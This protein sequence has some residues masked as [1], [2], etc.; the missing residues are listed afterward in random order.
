MVLD[1]AGAV[2]VVE[3][4]LDLV[5]VDAERGGAVAVD[6]DLDLR[7]LDLQ[8][9]GDVGEPGHLVQPPLE[10]R[11]PVVQRVHVGALRVNW[12]WLLD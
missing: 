4:V 8:V 11:G 2:G 10:R 6:P 7:I 3:R 12:Y 5:H 1:L 9:A